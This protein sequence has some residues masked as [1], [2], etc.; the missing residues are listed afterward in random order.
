[1]ILLNKNENSYDL[2]MQFKAEICVELSKENWNRYVS[3][4]PLTELLAEKFSVSPENVL[5]TTGNLNAIDVFFNYI[6]EKQPYIQLQPSYIRYNNYIENF[7]LSPKFVNF[8]FSRNYDDLVS[9][10]DA[11]PEYPILLCNPNNPTGLFLDIAKINNLL[12]RT[13][14]SLFIDATYYYFS[15]EA[16]QKNYQ[17]IKLLDNAVIAYSLSK[18]FG[19]AGVR[20]GFLIGD[21]KIIQKINHTMSPFTNYFTFLCFKKIMEQKW[22]NICINNLNNIYENKKRMFYSLN[23]IPNLYVTNTETNFLLVRSDTQTNTYALFRFFEE[24]SIYFK[25][26]QI[27]NNVFIRLTI[28]SS[29]ECDEIIKTIKKWQPENAFNI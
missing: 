6:V 26:I 5:L 15:S 18:S 9:V 16:R 8:T 19:M 4:E 10:V 22:W 12:S 25:L 3:I 1:M 7:K 2:S 21:K 24:N 11:F 28:G 23:K 17:I 13:K 27:S 29:A 14:S 20:L